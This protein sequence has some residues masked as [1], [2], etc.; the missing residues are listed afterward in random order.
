MGHL[1]DVPG[2]LGGVAELGACHRGGEGKVADRDFLVD[3][4]VGKVVVTLGHG[5]N[6]NADAL[7]WLQGLHV[8]ADLDDWCV[9]GKRDLAAVWWEVVGDW[10]LDHLEELLLRVRGANREAVQKLDHK[11]GETLKGTWN[12][13]SWADFD[14]HALGGRDVYLEEA[15]LVDRRIEESEQTL[16]KSLLAT[17]RLVGDSIVYHIPG[18]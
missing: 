2:V 8:L 10:V 9:E 17:C 12:A 11:A 5:T 15:S 4:L 13:D 18:G 16:L 1:N 7:I 14:E 6:E 3:V